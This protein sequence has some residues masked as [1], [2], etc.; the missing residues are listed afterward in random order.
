MMTDLKNYLANPAQNRNRLAGCEVADTRRCARLVLALAFAIAPAGVTATVAAVTFEDGTVYESFDGATQPQSIAAGDLNNDGAPDLVVPFQEGSSKL[1]RMWNDGTGHFDTY[2]YYNLPYPRSVAVGPFF[3]G[4]TDIAVTT[5]Q[6]E[7]Y[8]FYQNNPSSKFAVDNP[9]FI[10]TGDFNGDRMADLA[11]SSET[12][13]PTSGVNNGYVTILLQGFTGISYSIAETIWAPDDS[14]GTTGDPLSTVYNTPT[15]VAVGDINGDGHLDLYISA[16]YGN[17]NVKDWVAYSDGTGHFPTS[18]ATGAP[19]SS[20]FAVLADLDKVAGPELIASAGECTGEWS[21]TMAPGDSCDNQLQLYHPTSDG[22]SSLYT[23]VSTDLVDFPVQWAVADF[24]QDSWP[25]IVAAGFQYV[26]FGTSG[27]VSVLLNEG[28]EGSDLAGWFTGP[29]QI[30]WDQDNANYYWAVTTADF[31]GDNYPDVAATAQASGSVVVILNATASNAKIEA[32]TLQLTR[33]NRVRIPLHC[34]ARATPTCTGEIV[35]R[36]LKGQQRALVAAD[37]A[38]I[39]A[40]GR[41]K[42]GPGVHTVEI[43]VRGSALK[44]LRHAGYLD[45]VAQT[46]TRQPKGQGDAAHRRALKLH[47]SS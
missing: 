44:K 7:I 2:S 25:D 29:T 31:D 6:A 16:N 41:F 43:H 42:I 39:V 11:V 17:I 32:S 12:S 21:D 30:A 9:S 13:N 46:S 26:T 5:S 35:L 8:P 36:R 45:I 23:Q 28:S 4:L 33:S 10:A 1:V 14:F 38:E 18:T 47:A 27:F 20:Y 19:G 15:G 22:Y 34:F 3:S 40:S 24:N 37:A